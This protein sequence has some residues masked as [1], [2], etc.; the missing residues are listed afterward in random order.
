MALAMGMLAAREGTQRG[1]DLASA[2]VRSACSEQEANPMPQTP[3]IFGVPGPHGLDVGSAASLHIPA[4]RAEP[5][6]L[7]GARGGC[8]IPPPRFL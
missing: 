4:A 7:P 2:P 6:Q 5:E 3:E 8:C 1:Q